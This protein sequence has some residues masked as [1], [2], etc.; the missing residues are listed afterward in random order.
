LFLPH[1]IYHS[2]SFP[3][4]SSL[5]IEQQVLPTPSC[6]TSFPPVDDSP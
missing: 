1:S 4:H 2:M 6:L 5:K 3:H